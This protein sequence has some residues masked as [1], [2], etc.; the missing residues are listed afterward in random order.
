MMASARS[1][2]VTPSGSAPSDAHQQRFRF[3]LRQALRGQHVLHFAGADAE[4]QRT[5]SPV[6]AGVAVAADD[7]L[8]GLGQSQLRPDHVHDPLPRRT[9]HRTAARRLAAQF[10]RKV[11]IC[12]AAIGS[13]RCSSARLWWWGCCGR[14]WRSRSGRRT[15]RPVQAQS[16]EG[17]RRSHLVNE[18]QVNVEQIWLAG[19]AAHQVRVPYFFKQSVLDAIRRT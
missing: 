11:A 1:L 17:L 18:V 16:L 10:S 4:G 8:A 15:L 19:G 13:A 7:G 14:S 3:A 12:C 5:E 9:R 2:A 6:R